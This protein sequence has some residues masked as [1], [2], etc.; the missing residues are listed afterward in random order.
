MACL[1]SKNVVSINE[2]EIYLTELKKRVK[3][4]VK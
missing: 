4:A 2:F 1:S 3:E